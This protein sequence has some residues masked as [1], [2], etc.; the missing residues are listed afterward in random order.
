MKQFLRDLFTGVNNQAWELGRI[1]S[2]W[3]IFT[4]SALAGYKVY[5]GQAFALTEYATAMMIVFTGCAIFIGG[6]DMAKAGANKVD[7]ATSSTVAT[8][9]TTTVTPPNGGAQP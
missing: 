9:T 6:K 2:A 4:T 5:A 7:P 1:S 3:A 8:V